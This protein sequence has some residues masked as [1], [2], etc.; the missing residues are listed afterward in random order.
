MIARADGGGPSPGGSE[1]QADEDVRR[2]DAAPP[3]AR[4]GARPTA[5]VSAGLSQTELARRISFHRTTVTHAERGS[6]VPAA[7]FWAACDALLGAEGTLVSLHEAWRKA[8]RATLGDR[9]EGKG[10]DRALSASRDAAGVGEPT[11]RRDV[12]KLG[13]AAAVTPGS[14]ARVLREAAAEAAE[15]TRRAQASA[16]GPA[17]LEHL[18]NVV[19]DLNDAYARTPPGDLFDRARTYRHQVDRLIAGPKTLPEERELFAYAGWLSEILALL[20]HDLGDVVAAGAYCNDAWEHADHAGHAELCAWAM[21]AKSTISLYAGRPDRAFAAALRGLRAVPAGHPLAVR[22]HGQ[23]GR[24]AARLAQ[25]GCCAPEDC[26]GHLCQA[27][28]LYDAL[29]ARCPKRFGLDTAT[30]ASYAVHS[31]AA[32]SYLALGQFGKAKASAERA[33]TVHVSAPPQ[34]RSPSREAIARIDLGVALAALGEPEEACGLGRQALAS[35]RVVGSV[36]GRASELGT[37]VT[38]RYPALAEGRELVE[39]TRALSVGGR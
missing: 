11:E 3:P 10:G 39:Q 36:L 19:A 26:H 37:L 17:I 16:V 5:G 9:P 24:A 8:K 1:N 22:L 25:K 38:R 27:E 31:Y 33:L 12:L 34:D 15:L 20:A 30:L 21:D 35:G 4:E 28:A 23:A 6:Q 2:S 32:S 7:P 18:R 29:P 14:V 13:L